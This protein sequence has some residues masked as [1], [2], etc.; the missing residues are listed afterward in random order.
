MFRAEI[1]LQVCI[2]HVCDVTVE[3]QGTLTTM[4]IEF[5]DHGSLLRKHDVL[6]YFKVEVGVPLICAGNDLF[7][8]LLKLENLSVEDDFLLLKQFMIDWSFFIFLLVLH[9]L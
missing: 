6:L 7:H 1:D 2:L 8:T 5:A 4:E 3:S 9:E